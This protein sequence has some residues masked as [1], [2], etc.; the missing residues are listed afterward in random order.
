M[1]F[2]LSCALGAFKSEAQAET[3]SDETGIVVAYVTSWTNETKK[4]RNVY[5]Q[6]G[7]SPKLIE[8]KAFTTL[9]HNAISWG[10]GN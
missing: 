6:M 9:L 8:N 3:T 1:A 7:H 5:I 10:L 4:A 2:V